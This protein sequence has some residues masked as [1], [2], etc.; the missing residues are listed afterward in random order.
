MPERGSAPTAQRPG[1]QPAG[2]GYGT[3][4]TAVSYIGP[5]ARAHR[6]TQHN[7]AAGLPPRPTQLARCRD[8]RFPP[9]VPTCSLFPPSTKTACEMSSPESPRWSL[10][11]PLVLHRGFQ[12]SPD[13]L[14]VAAS[15]G[16]KGAEEARRR[17]SLLSLL[18]VSSGSRD[19]G[20]D[21][22]SANTDTDNDDD[23]FVGGDGDSA[24]LPESPGSPFP[25]S[26]PLPIVCPRCVVPPQ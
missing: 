3:P 23:Q 13:A 25:R 6:Q 16:I 8:P 26:A 2:P 12:C 24:S 15:R 22:H 5:Y 17:P 10:S 19:Q 7:S 4:K 20:T 1:G 14:V 9:V 11:E 21:S 18:L